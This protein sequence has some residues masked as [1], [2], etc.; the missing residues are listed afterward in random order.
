MVVIELHMWATGCIRLDKRTEVAKQANGGKG[1]Q[2]ARDL[3]G[4]PG[5]V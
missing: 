1:G 5:P 2:G 4:L 3:R